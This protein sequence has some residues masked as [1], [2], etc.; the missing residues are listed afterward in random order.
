MPESCAPV[1]TSEFLSDQEP[2]APIENTDIF[3][4]LYSVDI[5]PFIEPMGNTAI[6]YMEWSTVWRL[7]NENSKHIHYEVHWFREGEQAVPYLETALGYFVQVSVTIDGRTE[8][9]IYSL[10]QKTPRA[11]DVSVAHQRA[12]VKCIG[13]HGLGLQL[14]EKK[15]REALTHPKKSSEPVRIAPVATPVPPK[16]S[17]G[18]KPSVPIK[19]ETVSIPPP[20]SA[21]EGGAE[22]DPVLTAPQ[23]SIVLK[24]LYGWPPSEV[25]ALCQLF[26]A[27][28]VYELRFSKLNDVLKTIDARNKEKAAS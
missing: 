24:Q 5:A 25:D 3:K 26:K 17:G 16:A 4:R 15:S 18:P 11:D 20:S 28:N 10:E 6:T 19:N 7:A 14:W 21:E 22:G 23:A 8:T 13:R 1:T 2:I 27:K 9:E 12:L